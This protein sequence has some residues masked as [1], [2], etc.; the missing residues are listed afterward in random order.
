MPAGGPY[1]CAVLHLSGGVLP[2]DE[3]AARELALTKNQFE[4]VDGV[5]HHVEKD[6][7]LRVI[8]PLS[9]RKKLFDEAHSG[10]LGGH[11]RDAKM[12]S[13]LSRHYWWPGMR[14]DIGKWCRACITCATRLPG[15]A[16]KPPLVPTP[17]GGPFD[18]IGVDV[19]Q[20]PKSKR[21]NRYAV[22]F[23]NYLTKW[24]EAFA[25]RDQSALTIAKL[26]VE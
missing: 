15:R 5:L 26:L 17:V 7:T 10:K 11:L 20:F 24:V 19:I 23:V 12:H 18:R 13:V 22:V 3:T 8:P 4:I 1:P 2:D 14:A 6:K 16:P 25:T 9:S 21:G